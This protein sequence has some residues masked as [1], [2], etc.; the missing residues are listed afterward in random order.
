MREYP[1]LVEAIKDVSQI[2][3]KTI[4]VIWIS[5][6]PDY[7]ECEVNFSIMV[8]GMINGTQDIPGVS[9]IDQIEL[10]ANG[11]ETSGW[12]AISDFKF[13]L[14]K[15]LD[16]RKEIISLNTSGLLDTPLIADCYDTNDIEQKLK[17]GYPHY[18]INQQSYLRIITQGE[19]LE[20]NRWYSTKRIKHLE[21][22]KLN[23]QET[24]LWIM[25][26]MEWISSK[27]I[28]GDILNG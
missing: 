18:R 8:G 12:G 5:S 17:Y 1:S 24:R 13:H 16:I 27:R 14:P 2:M 20:I 19:T 11:I 6:F 25:A 3:R 15:E 23:D 26:I 22:V 21:T 9:I 10:K 7:Y 28:K 4:N